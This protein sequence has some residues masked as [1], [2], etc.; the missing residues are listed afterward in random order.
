[1]IGR[2]QAQIGQVSFGKPCPDLL[3]TAKDLGKAN[4]MCEQVR[5]LPGACQIPKPEQAA[6]RVE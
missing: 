1:V 6:L 4:A 3:H 2:M 5:D